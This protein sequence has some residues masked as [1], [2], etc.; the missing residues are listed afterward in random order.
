MDGTENSWPALVA[1]A[2]LRGEGDM[3]AAGAQKRSI[4]QIIADLRGAT[5]ARRMATQP[6]AP[7]EAPA[8]KSAPLYA[9]AQ[10]LER[11]G[12]PPGAIETLF[13]RFEPMGRLRDAQGSVPPS[14]GVLATWRGRSLR[15]GAVDHV[16]C[17]AESEAQAL[18]EACAACELRVVCNLWAVPR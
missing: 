2:A 14:V 17:L 15:R 12:L 18:L 13:L 3:W 1:T 11:L 10:S 4:W 5:D 9:F 6:I 7:F 16:R 8:S